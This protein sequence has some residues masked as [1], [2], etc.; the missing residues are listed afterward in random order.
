MAELGERRA[1]GRR[2]SATTQSSDV[3]VWPVAEERLGIMGIPSA[4]QPAQQTDLALRSVRYGERAVAVCQGLHRTS[5]GH[6]QML[7]FFQGF[8]EAD[9][10]CL[11]EAATSKQQTPR[12]GVSGPSIVVGS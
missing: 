9:T 8:K 12:V 1:C 6:A 4:V 3:S 2:P 10:A 7:T 5:R 11:T